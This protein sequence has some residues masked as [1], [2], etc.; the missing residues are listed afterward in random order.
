MMPAPEFSRRSAL[1][2]I[3][4]GLVSSQL[5]PDASAACVHLADLPDDARL[6]PLKDLNGYFPFTP[7]NTVAEW[8]SRREYVVRQLQVACGLWPMPERPPIEAVV[9]GRVERDGYTVDRVYFESSPGLLVTGS[10]YRPTDVRGKLPT[11][12]CPYG[13]WSNGRF[14]DHGESGIKSELESGAEVFPVGGRHPLQA[15]CVQL[16]RMG[17]WCSTMTCRAQQMAARSLMN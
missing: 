4:A 11:V 13:H 17:A 14:H 6:G 8:E 9:H 15:R 16:A 5:M 10:L 12:L 1:A 3:S 2:I 7:A